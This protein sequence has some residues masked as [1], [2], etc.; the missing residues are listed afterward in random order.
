MLTGTSTTERRAASPAL[1]RHAGRRLRGASMLRLARREIAT[2][3]NGVGL[4]L[5]VTLACLA[6]AVTLK[7][8]LDYLAANGTL[9]LAA[10][11]RAPLLIAVI[12]MTAFLGLSAAAGTAGERERGTL[13]VLMYGPVDIW[14]FVAGKALGLLG[15]Y[16]I[17]LLAVAVVLAL[18]ATLTAIPLDGATAGLL[19]LSTAP[20]ACTIAFG[21][22]LAAH[23]TRVRAAISLTLVALLLFA[24]IDAADQLL[25]ARAADG[26]LGSAAQLLAAV[27]AVAAWLS[28]FSYLS[29]AVESIVLADSRG[30][31]INTLAPLLYAGAL[32]CLTVAALR[33][34]G[35]QRWRE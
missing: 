26:A 27:A 33:R 19:A 10:P 3:L 21:M 20:A 11:L 32:L 1:E 9:V 14:T 31:A 22:L 4:Y 17:M 2:A 25:A 28:P 15:T 23:T 6:A 34:G 7:G 13:E 18:I 29:R 5:V 24:A 12:L 35:V 16:C 30:V 8:Y